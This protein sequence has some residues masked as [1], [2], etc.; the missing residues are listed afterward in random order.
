MLFNVVDLKDGV[1]VEDVEAALGG[2][3]NI[4]K[5]KYGDERGG[6]IAGQVYRNSGFVS[7]E[8]TVGADD[9]RKARRIQ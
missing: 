8:G 9:S 6:F 3:C 2:M 7:K 4:V 1:S 5:N